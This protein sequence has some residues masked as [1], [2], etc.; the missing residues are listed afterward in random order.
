M[1]NKTQDEKPT[2]PKEPNDIRIGMSSRVRNVIRYCNGLLKE[3]TKLLHFAAVGGAIGKLVN[4]VEVLKVVNPGLYQ[5]NKLATVSYQSVE[6]GKEVIKN[7]RLYPKLEVTLSLEPLDK[8]EGYQDMINE[9]E[10]KK[11]HE[12][13]N[14]QPIRREGM[15]RGRGG[16]RRG[17]GTFRRGRGTFRGGFRG[18]AGFR[19]RGTFRGR[20]GF[21]GGYSVAGRGNGMRRGRGGFRGG[22][23]RGGA[24]R[25]MNY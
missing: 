15:R 18:R 16:F 21:R 20:G 7:Q 23:G 3:Q 5:L 25:R 11:L 2:S 19:G 22:R 9:E 17:R 6:D 12:I 14:Q 4:I 13:F 24:N 10:R 8:T 1:S